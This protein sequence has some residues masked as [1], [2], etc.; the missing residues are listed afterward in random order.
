MKKQT[1][2]AIIFKHIHEFIKWIFLDFAKWQKLLKQIKFED[3][4][5]Y[6]NF[7]LSTI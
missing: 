5:K 7:K 6:L 3:I 2:G 1:I 4:T